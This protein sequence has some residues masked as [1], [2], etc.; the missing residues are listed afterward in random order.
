MLVGAVT[1]SLVNT[2]ARAAAREEASSRTELNRD[3]VVFMWVVGEVGS[4]AKNRTQHV[5]QED[6]SGQFSL[7]ESI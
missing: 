6:V 3:T 1:V 5:W 2:A 7:R 4:H